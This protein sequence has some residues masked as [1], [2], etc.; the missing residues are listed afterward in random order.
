MLFRSNVASGGT[1]I[2]GGAGISR[3]QF[4]YS[5]KNPIQNYGTGGGSGYYGGG[6][7]LA[8]DNN[9]DSGAG[10][11]SFISGHNGCDAIKEESTESNIIHTGQSIHYS[12]LYFTNTL[13]IDGE[14]YRW[15]DTKEEQIGMPSHSDNSIIMGNSGNGYARI[16]LISI[17]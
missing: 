5:V 9:V 14:G 6:S 2:N 12:G 16:T 15:T 8:T 11:S 7:G 17:D 13:M 3:S 1:Q 4:G 10:G